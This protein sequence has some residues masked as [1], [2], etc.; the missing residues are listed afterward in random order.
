MDSEING[1]AAIVENFN[2]LSQSLSYKEKMKEN[3]ETVQDKPTD[4]S[5]DSE[6]RRSEWEYLK[7]LGLTVS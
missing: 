1:N 4:G 2:K 3:F 5:A 7:T 6:Y